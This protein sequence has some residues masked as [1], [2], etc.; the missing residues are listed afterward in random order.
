MQ[1]NCHRRRIWGMEVEMLVSLN[2]TLATDNLE[3]LLLNIF[4]I[5]HQHNI[6]Y[7]QRPVRQSHCSDFSYFHQSL[8]S[9]SVI[10]SATMPKH[11][12]V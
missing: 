4:T 10:K 9:F 1:E 3:A 12:P 6:N 5:E 7:Y 11:E 8:R 2:M